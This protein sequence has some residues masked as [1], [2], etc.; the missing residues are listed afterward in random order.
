MFN[1]VLD[2]KQ[3]FFDSRNK[4]Q[5]KSPNFGYFRENSP[6]FSR[7]KN[8]FSRLYKQ[9][10]KKVETVRFFQRGW[11]IGQKFKNFPCYYLFKIGQENVFDDILEKKVLVDYITRS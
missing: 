9:S 11:S 4:D 8:S 1:A 2:R 5:S 3:D 7:K 10:D 6:G